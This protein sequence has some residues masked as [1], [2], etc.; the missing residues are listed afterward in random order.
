M[1]KP[2]IFLD[3]RDAQQRAELIAERLK[4]WKSIMSA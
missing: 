1:D 3:G 4:H 2:R